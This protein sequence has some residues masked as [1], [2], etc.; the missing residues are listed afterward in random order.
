MQQSIESLNPPP[1]FPA[2]IWPYG[3]GIE[4]CQTSV[5]EVEPEVSSLSSRIQ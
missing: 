2:V 4:P 1:P 5:E 3:G